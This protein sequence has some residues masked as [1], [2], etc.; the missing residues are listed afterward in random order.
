MTKSKVQDYDTAPGSNTDIAGIDIGENCAAA[1]INN[2][3]RALMGHIKSALSGSDDSI[4][5]GTAG[6]ATRVPQW[7]A[8]GD[9]VEGYA[10]LDEDDMASNSATGIPS[11]QSVKAYVDGNGGVPTGSVT[12]FAADTPPSGWL[13]CDGS[14]VS[15]TTYAALFAAIGTTF[16]SGDGSTTFNLPDLRGEFVRG[17]DNGKG[18]DSGRAF[19]SAQEDAFKT[20][21][22]SYDTKTSINSYPRG[23][24]STIESVRQG[25]DNTQTGAP[26]E[27][28][29]S[30]T[31]PR[32][33]ALLPIIKT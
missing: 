23:E 27:G 31:R 30:E 5:T 13:E 20:H 25:S 33:I 22:H 19:G 26:S 9:L 11:Q 1:N 16:G 32:N 29:G 10:F 4:I 24:Q 14:A 12:W 28:S 6:T 18:T 17:W 21:T 15:R 2:A 8:D 7:N 3:I